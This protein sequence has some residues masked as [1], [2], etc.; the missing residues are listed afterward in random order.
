[1]SGVKE[2]FVNKTVGDSV[3]EVQN[4]LDRLGYVIAQEVNAKTAIETCERAI[5]FLK[6][7]VI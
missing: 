3:G 6:V 2:I 4:S 1:M 7:S 5:D